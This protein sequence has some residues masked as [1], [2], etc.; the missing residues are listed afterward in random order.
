VLY[1][2][3]ML[4]VYQGRMFASLF[5]SPQPLPRALV[6]GAWVMFAAGLSGCADISDSSLSTAF[7]D[8][9]KYE[10]FDCKQLEAERKNLANRSAELKGLI[11]KAQA[12]VAGPVVAEIAYRNEYIA[13]RGQAR[14]ADEA[15]QRSNCHETPPAAKPAV[16]AGPAPNDK[17]GRSSMKSNNAVY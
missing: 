15:W 14:N 5:D 12:G 13:V 7:A 1:A 9:A 3:S 16:S 4:S 6:L 17:S 11:S 8:P 10:L 2:T